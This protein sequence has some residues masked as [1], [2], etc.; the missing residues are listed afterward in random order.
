MTVPLLFRK[1]IEFQLTY[2]CTDYVS[3][4]ERHGA[5]D[6]R[7]EADGSRQPWLEVG[8]ALRFRLEAGDR[9][10]RSEVRDQ[11]TERGLEFVDF[12]SEKSEKR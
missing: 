7:Q 8:G 1:V 9:G 2:R 10:R 6:S 4:M 5:E 11:R 3:R 12:S